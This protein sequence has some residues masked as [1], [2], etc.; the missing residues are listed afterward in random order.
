MLIAVAVPA[1]LLGNA[2]I[3]LMQPPVATAPYSAPGFPGPVIELTDSERDRLAGVGI[4]AVTPWRS[5]GIQAMREAERDSGAVAF[6]DEEI[7]HFDD[8][9]TIMKVLIAAWLLGWCVLIATAASR[10]RSLLRPGLRAGLLAT[11]GT[12]V[13]LGLAMLVAFDSFFEGFHVLLF[14]GDTWRLP[15]RGTVRSLFPDEYWA[16]MGGAVAAVVLAQAAVIGAL[17][18]RG[19]QSD[20]SK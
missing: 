14:E 3:V 11:A 18:Q 16:T 5:G 10:T 20:P 7:R 15:N 2:L 8:V 6:V 19:R 17:L 13:V 12:F 9:R 1:V 4:R